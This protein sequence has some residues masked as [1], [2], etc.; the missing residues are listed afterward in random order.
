LLDPTLNSLSGVS[1]LLIHVSYTD[2]LVNL[3]EAHTLLDALT[4]LDVRLGDGR[5]ALLVLPGQ[6]GHVPH[7]DGKDGPPGADA[8][9]KGHGGAQEDVAV[10]R[11]DATR[12][13]GDEHVDGAGHELLAALTGR[14]QRGNGA[15]EGLLEVEGRVHRL[16]DLVLGGDGELVQEE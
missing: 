10:A 1:Y 4:Q 15:G 14:G 12:H 2:I 16:V 6:V 13:G 8:E 5:E 9:G 3:G 11:D 7:G